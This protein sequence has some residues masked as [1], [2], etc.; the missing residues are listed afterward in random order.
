VNR[1]TAA[2]GLIALV[3]DRDIEEA[4]IKLFR[5]TA[6]LGVSP[7]T[8]DIRRHPD[9]D[10]GCR[11]DAANFLRQFLRAYRYALVVF[12]REGCGS[13][14]PR[15]EIEGA[16]EHK[17]SRNGWRRRARAVV[18]EPELEA[19]VWSGSAVVS[20][21]LGWGRSY[22]ELRGLLAKA[23][24]WGPGLQKP[25]DPKQAMITALRSAP[26]ATRRRRSPRIFGEIAAEVSTVDC[27]DPAFRKLQS[28]LREWFPISAG[29]D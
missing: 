24:L 26:R 21:A 29:G 4:L 14:S 9:R 7:F 16:A 22:D 8:F 20:N 18:I 10:A 3:A 6:S 5:R 11:A 27:Q 23:G 1:A 17:L 19:W 2:D 28:T 25:D 13:A 15:D 12:D